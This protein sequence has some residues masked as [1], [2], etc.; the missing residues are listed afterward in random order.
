MATLAL[1]QPISNLDNAIWWTE[2][3]IRHKGAKHLKGPAINIPWY[4]YWLIDVIGF[5]IVVF[6]LISWLL[7]KVLKS[8]KYL[9]VG[10]QKKE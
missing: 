8:V 7:I 6:L 9:I 2:Y 4:Q 5:F 10:K 3:V 1:D